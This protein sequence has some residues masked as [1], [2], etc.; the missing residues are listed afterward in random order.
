MEELFNVR[1][2]TNKKSDGHVLDSYKT[3]YLDLVAQSVE[4]L[5]SVDTGISHLS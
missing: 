1:F 3:L 4:R 2:E 5:T